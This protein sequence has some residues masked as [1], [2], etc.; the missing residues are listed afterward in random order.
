LQFND[1]EGCK[2]G[3]MYLPDNIG[4]RP[5]PMAALLQSLAAGLRRWAGELDPSDKEDRQ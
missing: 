2:Q 4:E 3:C 5:W 1:L